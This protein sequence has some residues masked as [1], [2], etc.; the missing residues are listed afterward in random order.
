MVLQMCG[1][2]R[3][4][5]FSWMKSFACWTVGSQSFLSA[6]PGGGDGTLEGRTPSGWSYVVLLPPSSLLPDT[7]H[8][9][10]INII[11]SWILKDFS[12]QENRGLLCHDLAIYTLPLLCHYYVLLVTIFTGT[13]RWYKDNLCLG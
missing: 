2:L 11:M 4:G 9:Y 3:T 7:P 1:N 12:Q 13:R 10:F 6:R 8:G 5:W